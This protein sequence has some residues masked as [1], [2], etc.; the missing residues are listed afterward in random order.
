M[1]IHTSK[2]LA[3]IVITLGV[4]SCSSSTLS[5]FGNEER[6]YFK[7]IVLE[8]NVTY[9]T[10]KPW[11]AVVRN[12]EMNCFTD[13]VPNPEEVITVRANHIEDALN[14]FYGTKGSWDVKRVQKENRNIVQSIATSNIEIKYEV[15][16]CKFKEIR[17]IRDNENLFASFRLIK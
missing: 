9:E 17:I 1:K 12:S 13:P 3:F 14:Y 5:K 15:A 2:I 10:T 7:E 16:Y 11:F 6:I 8:D 4:C